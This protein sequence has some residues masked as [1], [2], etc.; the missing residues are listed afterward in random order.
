LKTVND[1]YGNRECKKHGW[2]D[3]ETC[4]YSYIRNKNNRNVNEFVCIKCSK[5]K[6]IINKD[7]NS[8][9]KK[10]YNITHLDVI[11]RY[12]QKNSE[13]IKERRKRN[14]L[15][16]LEEELA[17]NR[18]Y[19][20][21]NKERLAEHNKR[22]RMELRV[23]VLSH[24]SP[25][26]CCDVCK[27]N[28]IEFLAIDHINGGGADHRRRCPSSE[29]MYRDIK[30]SGY[31]D[32]FRVLCHNCNLKYRDDTKLGRKRIVFDESVIAKG[33]RA[34]IR[35]KEIKKEVMDS[36][37]GKCECCGINDLDVLTIDHIYGGGKAHCEEIGGGGSTLYRWLRKKGYPKDKF[38]CLCINCNK[39]HGSYGYCPHKK[40]NNGN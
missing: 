27:E 6:S 23:D 28:N 32:G 30:K 22:K 31:P 9:Y 19:K 26:M 18:K 25:E 13:K 3:I 1:G 34:K 39:S 16:F 21:E 24:Y 40:E 7:R 36:Y 20:L 33:E 5:E 29:S 10:R 12:N 11:E 15:A 38:R 4:Y 37:G 17:Y 14:R 2:Q 35:C 8:E